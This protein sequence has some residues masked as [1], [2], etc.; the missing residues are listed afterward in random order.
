M[1]QLG[2]ETDK[3]IYDKGSFCKSKS[4]QDTKVS[5]LID[6]EKKWKKKE[7]TKNNNKEENHVRLMNLLFA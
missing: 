7:E 2:A 4:R 3:R 5:C 6:K 1:S